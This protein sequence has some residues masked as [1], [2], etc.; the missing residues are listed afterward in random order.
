M[1]VRSAKDIKTHQRKSRN[2][3][4]LQLNADANLNFDLLSR[5][6]AVFF[7]SQGHFPFVIP[8]TSTK[9]HSLR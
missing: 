4:Q 6:P 3:R 7:R 8:P 1:T 9:L 5:S 2:R